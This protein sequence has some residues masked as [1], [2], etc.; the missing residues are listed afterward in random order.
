MPKV[1]V[2]LVGGFLG[3]GKT[4][5]VSAASER[6]AAQGKRVG[7]I[8]NDQAAN[9]VDT[10]TLARPGLPVQEVS[11]GCFC[12][13][14]DDLV[15]AMDR[16]VRTETPEVLIGEPVGSCT[17]LS[18]TVLQPMKRL[19]ADRFDVAPFSVLV[20]ATQLRNALRDDEGRRFPENVIYIFRKQ[21]EEADVILLNKADLAASE[22][23]AELE[24]LLRQIFPQAPVMTVSALTGTGV[25]SWLNHVLNAPGAGRTIADVDY[26][27]YAEGEAA[28]GWLNA[29]VQLHGGSPTDWRGFC[30]GLIEAMR[31]EF[32]GVAA[33]VA[34][35]KLHLTA[36]EGTLVA[37]LTSSRDGPSIRGQVEPWPPEA[38]LLVNVRANIGPAQL[39]SITERCLEAVAGEAIRLTV[40]DLRSFAPARPEPT[41]RF[42][43]VV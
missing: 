41:H 9:L 23:L 10:A 21:L 14:F 6:L 16:L 31:S 29:A 37:N 11:G 33:E 28:L 42:P 27:V 34:H 20:D 19:L 35:L 32:Q 25:D 1:R 43:S 39:R 2:I 18:A 8:T 30:R 36:G 40:E 3:A 5:L 7:L 4:T 38:R 15:T 12:C 26:D 24:R 22:E 13:H 17:D